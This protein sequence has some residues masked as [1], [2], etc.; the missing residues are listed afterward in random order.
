MVEKTQ[1]NS[2]EFVGDQELT[3]VLRDL[4]PKIILLLL[5]KAD[6]DYQLATGWACSQAGYRGMRLSQL[7]LLSSHW[8][9]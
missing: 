6:A 2:P 7:L 9:W 3:T 8:G 5:Y 1:E 4:N